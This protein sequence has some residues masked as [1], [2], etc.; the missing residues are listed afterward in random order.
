MKTLQAPILLLS[1]LTLTLISCQEHRSGRVPNLAPNAHQVTAQEVIQT[2]RYT[3]IRVLS[4]ND[5]DYWIAINKADIQEEGTYFWS[6]GM[7]MTNFTSKE[8]NRTFPSIYFVQDFTDQPIIHS[9]PV[10]SPT[11]MAGRP[12]APEDGGIRVDKV[13]GGYT[14]A[15]LFAK[16]NT[17][18]GNTVLVRGKVVKF[19]RQIMNR[20]WA[21]I[22]DG[23]REGDFYDLA[24]TTSDTVSLGGVVIFEGKVSVQKDFGA[25]YVYDLILEDAR[26][27]K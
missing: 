13:P 19:S 7:E 11:T 21:H 3:Y 23:T 26:V 20:N 2:S 24:V 8:L 4:E 12:Q 17:L 16:R 25:G 15:E 27:R 5:Q 18:N 14:V 22:Q 1:T 9:N 6:E 10:P